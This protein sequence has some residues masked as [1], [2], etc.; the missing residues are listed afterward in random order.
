MVLPHNYLLCLCP[1]MVNDS[2][3]QGGD[4]KLLRGSPLLYIDK[5]VGLIA[6]PEKNR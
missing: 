6:L 5:R 3:K 4:F 1:L 2:V